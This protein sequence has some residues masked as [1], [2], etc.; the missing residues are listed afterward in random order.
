MQKIL[1]LLFHQNNRNAAQLADV[2]LL[3]ALKIMTIRKMPILLHLVKMA[4]T[5]L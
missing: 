4:R 1:L 2:L 5:C 3:A